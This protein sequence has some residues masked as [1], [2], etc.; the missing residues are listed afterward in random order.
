MEQT[1][2]LHRIPSDKQKSAVFCVDTSLMWM[3]YPVHFGIRA[4][5]LARLDPITQVR[6]S[7]RLTFWNQ[8]RLSLRC[9]GC[10]PMWAQAADYGYFM[11]AGGQNFAD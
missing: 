9:H 11:Q 7:V 8:I 4:L 1:Q 5:I 3:I 6:V 2:F 10:P